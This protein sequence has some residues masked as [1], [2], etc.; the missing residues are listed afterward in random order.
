MTLEQWIERAEVFAEENEAISHL[1]LVHLG[2]G[3]LFGG[4]IASFDYEADR[5]G[6]EKNHLD[7]WFE[8]PDRLRFTAKGKTPAQAIE[9]AIAKSIV[10]LPSERARHERFIKMLKQTDAFQDAMEWADVIGD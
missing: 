1:T 7:L 3:E 10:N 4:W 6:V 8:H 2:S 5:I 9:N